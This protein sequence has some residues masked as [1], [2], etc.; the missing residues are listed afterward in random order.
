MNNINYITTTFS[1]IVIPKFEGLAAPKIRVTHEI[2]RLN[3]K[4]LNIS[5]TVF[6]TLN[7]IGGNLKFEIFNA[8]SKYHIDIISELS[9]DDLFYIWSQSANYLTKEYNRFEISKNMRPTNIHVPDKK[10]L[11]HHLKNIVAWFYSP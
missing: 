11:N 2:D 9:V 7:E 8:L 10:E 4:S 1:P 6:L 3:A 5:I